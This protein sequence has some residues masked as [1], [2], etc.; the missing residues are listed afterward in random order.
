M[1]GLKLKVKPS[2]ARQLS[3]SELREK[4]QIGTFDRTV[5]EAQEWLRLDRVAKD[6]NNEANRQKTQLKKAYRQYARDE[7]ISPDDA[8][9]IGEEALR[10]DVAYAEIIDPND[11][12]ALLQEGKI[13]EQ[14]FLR[15]IKVQKEDCELHCGAFIVQ[16]L[17]RKV[18][19]KDIDIRKTKTEEPSDRPVLRKAGQ[20]AAPVKPK[21]STP[22][23][24]NAKPLRAG[25]IR[26][27]RRIR[28]V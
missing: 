5:V 21:Q 22:V 2:P 25:T 6:A 28:N 8:I 7:G 4:H 12:Y 15:S 19:G 17:S 27:V 16:D 24:V 23:P 1:P 11:L 13:T 9:V 3:I 20:K 10:L 18:A 14:Q 26:P